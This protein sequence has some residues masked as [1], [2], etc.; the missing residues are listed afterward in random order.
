M[1]DIV[2]APEHLTTNTSTIQQ[3][4]TQVQSPPTVETVR[5]RLYLNC[6]R[7]R[8][9]DAEGLNLPDMACEFPDDRTLGACVPCNQRL[10]RCIPV[11]FPLLPSSH[12]ILV[13]SLQGSY[14]SSSIFDRYRS[15]RTGCTEGQHFTQAG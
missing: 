6:V 14:S 5:H 3:A 15:D 9:D 4:S 1:A 7:R 2:P 8:A 13:N 12:V 10:R 11:R